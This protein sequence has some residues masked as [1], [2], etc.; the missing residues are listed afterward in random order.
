MNKYSLEL[1]IKV[2]TIKLYQCFEA[3]KSKQNRSSLDIIKKEDHLLFKI[4]SKDIIALKATINSVIKLLEV[5]EN[6]SS[7][8]R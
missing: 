6:I 8:P 3:E 4:D 5:E 1:K 7:L 2:D